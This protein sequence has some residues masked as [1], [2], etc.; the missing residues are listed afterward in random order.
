M[1]RRIA[2][3]SAAAAIFVLVF[4]GATWF[5]SSRNS[6]SASSWFEGALH[7]GMTRDQVRNL[8]GNDHGTLN[9]VPYP[10]ADL[11]MAN[12]HSRSLQLIWIQKRASFCSE[13]S[14]LF[15]LTYDRNNKLYSWRKYEVFDG[16]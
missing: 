6:A 4:C 2:F 15:A 11:I 1:A 10:D 5:V 8:G 3:V 9:G 14:D 16:C 7:R 13:V 12:D